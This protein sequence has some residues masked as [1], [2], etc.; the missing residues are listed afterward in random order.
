MPKAPPALAAPVL[1]VKSPTP[2]SKKVMVRKKKTLIKE[3]EL[4]EQASR[5]RTV[6]HKHNSDLGKV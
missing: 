5:K 3:K 4:L 1:P 2:R 6:A